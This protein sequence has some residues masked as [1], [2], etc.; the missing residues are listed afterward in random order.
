MNSLVSLHGWLTLLMGA[1][2]L[3]AL[4][5]QQWHPAGALSVAILVAGVAL[6]GLPHGAFDHL[7]GIRLIRHWLPGRAV[8][9]WLGLFLLVYVLLS[10]ALLWGWRQSPAAALTLFLLLSAAHFGTDWRGRQPLWLRLCWGALVI[11]APFAWRPGEV[12]QVVRALAVAD[13]AAFTRAGMFI[14][15]LVGLVVLCRLRW[16]WRHARGTLMAMAMLVIGAIVLNPLIYFACYFC[17]FHSPLHL[18]AI[19][20]E[21]GLT[22]RARAVGMAAPIVIVTWVGASIGY[23]WMSQQAIASPLLKTTFIG[24]ACLTVPHMIVEWLGSRDARRSLV[25]TRPLHRQS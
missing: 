2:L 12:G 9:I 11:A 13:P 15:T 7:T 17:C 21:F 18:S 3:V 19:R 14:F 20:R 5:G 24:L 1:A 6:L 16:L 22:S 10:A 8:G 23:A 25:S 4:G